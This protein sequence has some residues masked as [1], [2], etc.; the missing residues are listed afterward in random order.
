[1]I[2][3][4]IGQNKLRSTPLGRAMRVLSGS[5]DWREKTILQCPVPAGNSDT[6]KEVQGKSIVD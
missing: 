4:L 5:V 1:L 2:F 3:S 6:S